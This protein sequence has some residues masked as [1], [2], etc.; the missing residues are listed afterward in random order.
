MKKFKYKKTLIFLIIAILLGVGAYLTLGKKP[1][2]EYN[3]AKAEIGKIIQTVS[4][5]GTVKTAKEINLNF[6]S[7]GKIAKQNVKIGDKVVKDQLLGELDYTNLKIQEKQSQANLQSA[8]ANLAKVSN[9]STVQDIAINQATANQ[10]Q[11]AYLNSLDDLDNTKKTVNEA[12]AQAQKNLDDLTASINQP[13]RSSFQQAVINRKDSLLTVLD[14]KLSVA[15]VALDA[16]NRV[17]TDQGAKDTISIQDPLSLQSAQTNYNDGISQLEKAN[18]SLSSAK[19]SKTDNNLTMAGDNVLKTLKSTLAALNAA[20]NALQ[21]TVTSASFSQ[22]TLDNL[23]ATVSSQLS[24]INVAI[25]TV[26]GG[27]QALNDATI[28]FNNAVQSARFNLNNSQLSAS[29]QIATA[30]ARVDANF[31]NWQVAKAQLEKT[32]AGPRGEDVKQADAQVLQAQAALDSVKNQITNSIIK[33]PINGVVTKVNYEVGEEANA[34]K[35]VFAILTEDSFEIDVDVSEA[36]I[37]KIKTSNPVT[38][39]FDAFGDAVKFKADLIFIEPAQTVIQDVVY[40]KTT[41]S[42]IALASSSREIVNPPDNNLASTTQANADLYK[43]IKPGMTANTIIT[44]AVKENVLIVPNRSIIEKSDGTKIIRVLL[45][46]QLIE[47][48]V[49]VGLKGDDGLTEIISGIS[50]GDE[51]ITSTK[52]AK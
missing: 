49:A 10:A 29:Q 22:A 1:K 37:V 15:K 16:V 36:D 39:T 25:T 21:K 5:T 51:V 6:L 12:V 42:N 19:S 11:A 4:E 41:I 43:S 31:N 14:D 30:K 3:T 33:S 45:N 40:Y 20:F 13:A 50:A 52:A 9:G 24:A 7:A 47:K 28:A 26:Q 38:V 48:P 34:S 44:T 18:T 46:N 2:V 35:P 32:V 23:K 17:L 27:Q 8:T